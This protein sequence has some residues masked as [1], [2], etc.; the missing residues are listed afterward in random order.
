MNQQV[1]FELGSAVALPLPDA[2]FD[3]ALLLHVGMNVPNKAALFREARRVLRDGGIFAVYDVMRTGENELTVP[4]P[5]AETPDQS[6]LD[7]PRV[8]RDAAQAAGFRLASE[9]DLTD[10]ARGFFERMQ[11]Q[12]SGGAPPPLGLHNLM[13]ATA[14]N[15]VANMVAG[16]RDGTIA[17]IQM[18]FSTSAQ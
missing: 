10:V 15:K 18:I 1:R 8:Y 5:W 17:P 7:T 3:I 14:K 6:S 9:E 16:I 4:V 13:G 2:G 12:A 11:A